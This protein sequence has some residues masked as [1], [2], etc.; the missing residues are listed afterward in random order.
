M[1]LPSI[2]PALRDEFD[3]SLAQVGGVLTA[4]AIGAS[5]GLIPWGHLADRIGERAVF[6]VGSAGV[7][8]SLC[9]TA[10]APTFVLLL[11]AIVLAGIC[12]S[13]T[14]GAGARMVM[15]WFSPS[16]RGT[17]LGI[18]QMAVPV[19]GAVAS[20]VLPLICDVSDVRAAI[21]FLAGMAATAS[22]T[23]ATFVRDPPRVG[24]KPGALPK[25]PLDGRQWRLGIA[26][27]ML[28][29]GQAVAVGFMVLFLHDE[30]HLPVA[31]AAV[32]L[33]AVQLLGAGA[34][35]GTGWLSDRRGVRLPLM[36]TIAT[37]A[38]VLFVATAAMTHAPLVLL[39]PLLVVAGVSALAWSPLAIAASA[40][41]AGPDRAGAATGFMATCISVG[42]IAA[43]TTFGAFVEATSWR[44][45]FAVTAIAPL[46]GA[47]ILKTLEHDEADRMRRRVAAGSKTLKEV[48]A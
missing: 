25:R 18:R 12:G 20:L 6:S 47:I 46:V 2:T 27:A 19:G 11:I 35:I 4:L 45:G 29:I 42:V 43:P 34:R 40:E 44:L 38:A 8:V 48:A 5:I 26:T 15:G 21:L 30:R 10:F 9:L 17:A 24:G 32:C 13:S 39:I 3:L 37:L 36:R 22:V 33:A 23:A 16:E 7:A 1:G 14:A 31:S 28:G 41:F